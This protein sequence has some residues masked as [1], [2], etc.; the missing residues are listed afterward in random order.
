[1]TVYLWGDAERY[2][3][4]RRAVERDRERK[5][6][7]AASVSV[8]ASSPAALP[9]TDPKYRDATPSR[10]EGIACAGSIKAETDAPPESRPSHFTAMI[11][12]ESKAVRHG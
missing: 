11:R 12:K 2:G 8:P 3:T 6:V 4:Y 1:M 7:G 5:A 9:V 10:R